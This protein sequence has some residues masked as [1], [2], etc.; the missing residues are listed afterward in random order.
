MLMGLEGR[1]KAPMRPMWQNSCALG[2]PC[3]IRGWGTMGQ[4]C[5]TATSSNRACHHGPHCS[6]FSVSD[7]VLCVCFPFNG[8]GQ[9]QGPFLPPHQVSCR[10]LGCGNANIRPGARPCAWSIGVSGRTSTG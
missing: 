5:F 9:G 3:V 1:G 7:C 4:V 6:Q 2:P 10:L 8:W